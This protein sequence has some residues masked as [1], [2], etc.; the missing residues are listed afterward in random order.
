M[1][2][3]V[4]LLFP[5]V[6]VKVNINFTLRYA[7]KAQRGV[8]MYFCSSLTSV[9]DGGGWSTP[10]PVRFTPGNNLLPIAQ[11]ASWAPGNVW[12]GTKNL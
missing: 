12:T 8:Q 10:S 2:L 7:I 11:E 1:T 4:P 3:S 5:A 9:L 6:S